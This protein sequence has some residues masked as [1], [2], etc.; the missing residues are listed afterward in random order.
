VVFGW[1]ILIAGISGMVLAG[2]I[3][4][5]ATKF[6]RHQDYNSSENNLPS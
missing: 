1:K 4:F 3:Y 5:G 6:K 2:I